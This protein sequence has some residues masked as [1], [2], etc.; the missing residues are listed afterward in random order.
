MSQTPQTFVP[1]VS[2]EVPWHTRQHIQLIYQ[3]LN[4]HAQAFASIADTANNATTNNITEINNNGGGGGGGGTPF[5]YPGFGGVNN[6]TGNTAYITQTSDNGILILISDA[7][8]VTLTLNSGVTTPFFLFV[9]NVGSGLAT[10][11]PSSGS[12]NSASSI[13][14]PKNGSSVIF[15]DGTN[16]W[17]FPISNQPISF[18]A[19][20]HEFLNSYD[21]TTGLFT[22]VQPSFSDISGTATNA[23]I[24][25]AVLLAPTTSQTV[26]QP[27]GTQFGV[28]SPGVL[29]N[30]GS[31]E[32]VALPVGTT[33]GE[34]IFQANPSSSSGSLV[35]LSGSIAFFQ[36]IAFEQ[37]VI[38][39]ANKTIDFTFGGS[40]A[41]IDA[42]TGNVTL[43]L[44]N[45]ISAIGSSIPTDSME[46]SVIRDDSTP[47]GNVVTIAATSPSTIQGLP[48][49][50]LPNRT[51]VTLLLTTNPGT[52]STTWQIKTDNRP[53]GGTVTHTSTALTSGSMVIGNG[54]SDVKVAPL[55]YGINVAG[56]ITSA[57]PIIISAPG[58]ANL[59]LELANASA[60]G[61]A[62]IIQSSAGSGNIWG[63]QATGTTALPFRGLLFQ[64]ATGGPI[65]LLLSSSSGKA[66][67]SL[68]ATGMF[69]WY[70]GASPVSTALDTGLSRSGAAT[71]AV[72]NG[73]PGNAS[74]TLTATNLHATGAYSGTYATAAITTGG[75]QGSVTVV[76]G[77]ITVVVPA[78]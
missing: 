21:A 2:S 15:F 77:I 55:D 24:P 40:A 23:Q 27:S 68:L 45:T 7:S 69:G 3:K 51:A 8:P 42:S 59:A 19:V 63:I 26:I 49:I 48:S 1:Q 74:G 39:T 61:S 32:Y 41:L 31:Q 36:G 44:P 50:D 11:V 33:P 13:V 18:P 65:N 60:Q 38:V 78:T 20:A 28:T 22:A 29:V 57:V 9:T 56:T 73:T 43:T 62:F 67:A 54:G 64:D 52:G 34:I 37:Y 75:T 30:S 16:W 5:A 25:G 58:P 72:G 6:Q 12:I 4:N 70:A 76:D 17:A 47:S 71:V 14:M 10:I 46:V 35:Q 53:S 66:V